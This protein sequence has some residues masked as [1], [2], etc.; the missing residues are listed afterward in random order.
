[1]S[2][3]RRH[4]RHFVKEVIDT[5]KTPLS[6]LYTLMMAALVVI[7]CVNF[8]VETYVENSDLFT[9]L[10]SVDAFITVLFLVDYLLRFWCSGFSIRYLF[11]PLALIDLISVLPLFGIRVNQVHFSLFYLLVNCS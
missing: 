2:R 1:M 3:N 5:E 8:V 7:I 4:L 11:T 6:Q 9:F 10:R